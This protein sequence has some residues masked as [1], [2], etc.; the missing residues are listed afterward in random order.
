MKRK[1]EKVSAKKRKEPEVP[2]GDSSKSKRIGNKR[3]E[4]LEQMAVILQDIV[5][6]KN[7]TNKLENVEEIPE[8]VVKNMYVWKC[9]GGEKLHDD[10]LR[11]IA[12]NDFNA[13]DQEEIE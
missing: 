12:D 7:Q 5:Y 3:Q 10:V 13:S 9:T 6:Q 4:N 2:K 11:Q 8:Y 1:Q